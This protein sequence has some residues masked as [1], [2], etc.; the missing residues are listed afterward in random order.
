[1]AEPSIASI[2]ES[3]ASSRASTR[4]RIA[5]ALVS[6]AVIIAV[7]VAAARAG[8]CRVLVALGSV[9]FE[10]SPAGLSARVSGNWEFDNI[11]QVVSGLS[12]NVVLVREDHF[13]RLHYPEGSFSGI[14]PGLGSRIDA[15]IDGN[16]IISIEAAGVNEPAARFVSLEAQRLK[17]SSPVPEG[18]GPISVIAY[19]VLDGDYVTP[20]I[21]NTITRPLEP[22]AVPVPDEGDP[23]DPT[24]TTLPPQ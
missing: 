17:V 6:L 5:V 8:S 9:D 24:P 4:S 2:E 22:V 14:V 16:D 21:S 20:I 12:Y 18:D 10:P 13:V 19:I 3:V 11:I 23:A 1:M 7:G 15:G